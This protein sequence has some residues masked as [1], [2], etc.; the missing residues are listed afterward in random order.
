MHLCPRRSKA[1]AGQE[2]R[3]PPAGGSE[4]G[5]AD[6][7][8]EGARRDRVKGHALLFRAQR[9]VSPDTAGVISSHATH[10]GPALVRDEAGDRRLHSLPRR[11]RRRH[12]SAHCASHRAFFAVARPTRAAAE[13]RETEGGDPVVARSEPGHDPRRGHVVHA[14][15]GEHDGGEVE[16]AVVGPPRLRSKVPIDCLLHGGCKCWCCHARAGESMW[17]AQLAETPCGVVRLRAGRNRRRLEGL[18]AKEGHCNAPLL[19]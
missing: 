3:C 12:R 18:L 14:I 1:A 13:V 17:S 15:E 10:S 9:H 8:L 16:P 19:R 11:R 5:C 7:H 4:N 2:A 6:T